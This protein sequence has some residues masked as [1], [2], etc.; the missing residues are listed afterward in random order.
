MYAGQVGG[1]VERQG[2]VV[3]DLVFQL[4]DLLDNLLALGLLF[5]IGSLGDRSVDV[6]NGLGL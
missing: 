6:I 5:G 2:A 4:G 3:L 1:R